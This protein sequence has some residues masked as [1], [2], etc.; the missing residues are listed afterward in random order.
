MKYTEIGSFISVSLLK[1]A[2]NSGE[3][4]TRNFLFAALRMIIRLNI[5]FN[6]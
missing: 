2:I 6:Q 3:I 1:S 5:L 4:E